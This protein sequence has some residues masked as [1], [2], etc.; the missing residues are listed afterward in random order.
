MCEAISQL[1]LSMHV[2]SCL[3]R[4]MLSFK[5]L[6]VAKTPGQRNL[7]QNVDCPGDL[8]TCDEHTATD[9]VLVEIR[10]QFSKNSIRYNDIKGFAELILQIL[11][12]AR[13]HLAVMIQILL[14]TTLLTASDRKENLFNY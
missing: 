5:Q 4:R 14:Q 8:L 7:S 1:E 10:K 11:R 9:N 12:D 6:E 2:I 3:F 13:C